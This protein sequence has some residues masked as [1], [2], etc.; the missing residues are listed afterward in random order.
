M[1]DNAPESTR[2]VL[3]YIVHSY[4]PREVTERAEATTEITRD[5]RARTTMTRPRSSDHALQREYDT[6]MYRFLRTLPGADPGSVATDGRTF[7]VEWD[8]IRAPI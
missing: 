3:R 6:E 5:L 1:S 7:T 4:L 2:R 8:G